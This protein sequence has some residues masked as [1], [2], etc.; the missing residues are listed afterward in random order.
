MTSFRIDR[1]AFDKTSLEAWSQVD[2]RHRNWPVVYTLDSSNSV[3]V[4]ESLNAA[5]RFGQ[6]LATPTKA[7]LEHATVVI[8]ETFNKSACLDLESF[9]IRMLAGDGRFS[10]INRNEGITN[11]DYYGRDQ[12]QERFEE[13]FEQLRAHGM[14]ARSI[15]EIE[16]SDLF[17]L[18]PF[19]SL[20]HDQ[21]IAVEDILEGLFQD[22]QAGASSQ[23]VIQG[24]PGTGKTVVAIFL[25]KLLLDIALRN[26][27]ENDDRDSMFSEF[28]VEG[29][30]ELLDGF[31]VGLVIPQQS[32]RRSISRVFAKTPGLSPDMVMSPFQLGSRGRRFDLLIVDETHR[33]NQR[34]AQA[35]GPQ[36]KLFREI[37]EKLFDSDDVS[38]TQLDWVTALSTHQLL[39]L[40]A[41]QTVR[42]ADLPSS[43]TRQVISSARSN[44][45]FYPLTAQHRVKAGSDYVKFVR[46]LLS[47]APLERPDFGDYE[48][49]MFD[50]LGRM[51][52]VIFER[53]RTHG[54][55]RMV[56]GYAWP[57]RSKKD[58]TATD[59]HL[60][61]L[62]LQWNRTAVDWVNSPNSLHEV[63]SIHTIQGYDL[64]YAG[65]IIGPD[66]MWE[67]AIGLRFVRENYHD[68]AGKKNNNQL[69]ITY[70]DEDLLVYVR[71]VYAVLLTR[72]ILGTFVYVCD[73]ALRERMRELLL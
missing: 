60:D 29:H 46:G 73:P 55:A 8:D 14:F 35:S 52:E 10:V 3:Y 62:D 19:K 40:D 9:L 22:L 26:P 30:A 45:R 48:L 33:L 61:G 7:N 6:H 67:P 59:I 54:L 56:A 2:G 11:A 58:L 47:D 37:N 39:L 64:N 12:Y 17:K 28:F 42:P 20:T 51:R 49:R 16:N 1:L 71:N 43:M 21:A 68:V 70:S 65:V 41:D 50:D 5:M 53:E 66:L 24:E 38:H 32:L 18:S 36:N 72:G 15:P 57:W 4:G 63:G 27:H 13:I 34:A 23:I 44:D 31:S 25:M 69:G